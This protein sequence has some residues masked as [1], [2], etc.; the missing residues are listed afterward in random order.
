AVPAVTSTFFMVIFEIVDMFWIGNLGADSIAG[1]SAASFFVWMIRGLG[2]TVAS[3]SLALVARRTG[4][5][6]VNGLLKT[7][8]NAVEASF[9]FSIIILLLFFP[10]ALKIFQWI[11]LDPDVAVQ[12]EEYTVVFLAGVIFVYLMMTVE[13]II[14]GIG[15]T[16]NPMIITGISL[17]LN[18]VLDPIFI[19]SFGMGLKGAAYATIVSQM[20]GAL[21]MLV[22]LLRKNDR[23]RKLRFNMKELLSREFGRRF[24]N[25]V[26]IGGPIG[27]TDAGFSF[28]YLIL[29]GIIS[30]F[31]KEPLAAIGIAHRL[32]A[33]PFFICLGFSMAVEPMVGQF[34]GAKDV[35]KA[36]QSVYLALK[37]AAGI[38]LVL[39]VLYIIFAPYLFRLFTDDPS[40]IP[41]GVTYVRIISIFEVF[42]VF[43]IVLTGAFAGAGD[44][45]P[46]FLISFPVTLA[47]I[48]LS[49]L[50]AVTFGFGVNA[51]WWVVSL[52]MF[53]K[54]VLLFIQFRKGKWALKKI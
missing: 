42:L 10:L 6:D 31:G 32:E 53:V 54:G 28:I 43:E 13:F 1:L 26:K 23:I 41:Y 17:L 27:G 51:I 11:R 5:R 37:V 34:L 29:S 46:P 21:L 7:I 52:T 45:R 33:L 39:A 12:A 8:A 24:L 44:T 2:L 4:E 15:D 40:I 20:I 50:F 22:E 49:Y 38:L 25:I 36:K 16:R 14:R 3:G 30:I 35:E 48:P 18:V 9:V 47:R 19:F